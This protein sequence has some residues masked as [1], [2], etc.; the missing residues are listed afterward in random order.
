M[1][2]TGIP[3]P[4]NGLDTTLRAAAVRSLARVC[5]GQTYRNTGGKSTT[6]TAAQAA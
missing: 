3:P 1:D 6:T 5:S 4:R 2:N